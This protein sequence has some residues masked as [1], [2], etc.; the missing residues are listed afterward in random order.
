MK[1]EDAATTFLILLPIAFNAFFF[2][3]ARLFDYPDILRSPTAIILSRYEAGGVRLKLAWYGFLLTAILLAPLA[4]LMGQVLA[5][6]GLAVV[7]TAT[8]VGVL[9]AV[10][11]FLGLARW[12]FLVPALARTYHDPASSPATREATVAIFESFHRYLGVAVGECLGYLFT[13][14]WTVLVGVAML[15]SSAFESWL[16]LPGIA[17]GLVLVAGSLEFVGRFEEKGW[18]RASAIVPIAYT[19]WSLWLVGAGLVLFF[20]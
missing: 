1:I 8:V 14:V 9:A 17:I 6:D 5:R 3:L 16:A 12:P 18:K 15:Q 10:V 7:P 13:G 11:Q 20:G 4:V 2:L 19:A